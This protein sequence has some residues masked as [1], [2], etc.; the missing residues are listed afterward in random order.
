MRWRLVLAVLLP[1]I[2]VGVFN[3]AYVQS[4]QADYCCA[5]GQYA[6]NNV[7]TTPAYAGIDYIRATRITMI[8]S[9]G[10]WYIG[11]S[12]AAP[13]WTGL[14]SISAQTIDSYGD[15]LDY[16]VNGYAKAGDGGNSW[17]PCDDGNGRHDDSG[18]VVE[19]A[20]YFSQGTGD[21]DY[22]C[23]F[24]QT[25]DASE[26]HL[27][28]VTRC[29][30]E[31][32]GSDWCTEMDG[33]LQDDAYDTGVGAAA[34]TAF[35]GDDWLCPWDSLNSSCTGPEG[36][37]PLDGSQDAFIRATFGWDPGSGDTNWQVSDQ[38]YSGGGGWQVVTSSDLAGRSEY[39]DCSISGSAS[40][41]AYDTYSTSNSWDIWWKNNGDDC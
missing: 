18:G 35:A 32:T 5:N 25:I 26:N 36:G 22:Q 2:A 19:W 24:G 4:A 21:D 20:R 14:T 28:G 6:T 10:S 31:G 38:G 8:R 11:D 12:D 7:W 33:T 17:Y 34:E 1:V 39:K 13:F 15:T 16:I 3:Q 30:G 27:M 29:S 40:Q 23:K 9:A 41:W 37:Y